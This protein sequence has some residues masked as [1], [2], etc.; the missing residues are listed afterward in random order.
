LGRALTPARASSDAV[1]PSSS[2]GDSVSIKPVH[3]IV[4]RLLGAA[5]FVAVLIAL[6]T[7]ITRH[8]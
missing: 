4:A 6:V 2:E 3:V 1:P 8:A 7:F 5:L